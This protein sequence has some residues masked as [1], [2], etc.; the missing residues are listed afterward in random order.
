MLGLQSTYDIQNVS[1]IRSAASMDNDRNNRSYKFSSHLYGNGGDRFNVIGQ[2]NSLSRY[3][4]KNRGG[5]AHQSSAEKGSMNAQTK[6]AHDEFVR[7]QDEEAIRD[8]ERLAMLEEKL[9]LLQKQKE[10]KK[11]RQ[12]VG[13]GNIATPNGH[14]QRPKLWRTVIISSPLRLRK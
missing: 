1:R 5:A 13:N 3:S 4:K 14:C 9:E 6:L 11:K 10:L 8:A 7:R 2:T 12:R